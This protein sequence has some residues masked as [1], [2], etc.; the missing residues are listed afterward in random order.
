MDGIFNFFTI[1]WRRDKLH[2]ST[3]GEPWDLKNRMCRADNSFIQ[4]FSSER[5][6]FH[7]IYCPSFTIPTALS[8]IV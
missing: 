1:P 7:V 6:R 2:N 8:E 5:M 4:I 3:V